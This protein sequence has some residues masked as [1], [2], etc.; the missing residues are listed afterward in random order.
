[1][2]GK[3]VLRKVE[4]FGTNDTDYWIDDVLIWNGLRA[5]TTD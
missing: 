4:D 3:W 5:A 2:S 1:M